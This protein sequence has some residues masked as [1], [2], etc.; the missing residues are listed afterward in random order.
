MR[1]ADRQD[2]SLTNLTA[3]DRLDCTLPSMIQ[4][5][6]NFYDNLFELPASL[7]DLLKTSPCFSRE[8]ILEP[9]YRA[10]RHAQKDMI[11]NF[12][13]RSIEELLI[14]TMAVS[15]SA[16][17]AGDPGYPSPEACFRVALASFWKIHSEPDEYALPITLCVALI[18]LYFF[19]RPFHSLGMLRG[20]GP[21]INRFA[22]SAFGDE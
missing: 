1:A 7:V 21:A 14:E 8:H 9:L 18:F 4:C 10:R 16:S 12:R 6:E 13:N 15:Y 19:A 22:K 20:V 5:M 17:K 2:A 3:E 11:D